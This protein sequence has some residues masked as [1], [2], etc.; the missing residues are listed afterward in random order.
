M[1]SAN[2]LI[3]EAFDNM[4]FDKSDIIEQYGLK[5]YLEKIEG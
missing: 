3:N 2:Q 4:F 5:P 1:A